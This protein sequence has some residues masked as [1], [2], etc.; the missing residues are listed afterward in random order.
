MNGKIWSK[1]EIGVVQFG[2]GDYC[3][4]SCRTDGAVNYNF[5]CNSQLEDATHFYVAFDNN[6]TKVDGKSYFHYDAERSWDA[7]NFMRNEPNVTYTKGD[8]VQFV[9]SYE[10]EYDQIFWHSSDYNAC[11]EKHTASSLDTFLSGWLL[12]NV[13]GAPDTSN[14]YAV[15]IWTGENNNNIHATFTLGI[16]NLDVARS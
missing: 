7:Y 1:P 15:T 9:Q 6:N 3:I 11:G 8:A 14:P 2:A 4:S 5:D 13:D 10:S 12:K 16:E